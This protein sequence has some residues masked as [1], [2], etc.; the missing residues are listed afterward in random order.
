M[1]GVWW[2]LAI[3]TKRLSSAITTRQLFY[4]QPGLK[5]ERFAKIFNGW[6]QNAPS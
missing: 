1:F 5:M 6:K 2:S 3:F 4:L